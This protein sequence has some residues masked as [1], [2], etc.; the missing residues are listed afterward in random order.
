MTVAFHYFAKAPKNVFFAITL[1]NL[2]LIRKK[3]KRKSALDLL[4]NNTAELLIV[5][6]KK[7][8]LFHA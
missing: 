2:K 1:F 7:V 8:K 5:K 4:A 6:G 3:I